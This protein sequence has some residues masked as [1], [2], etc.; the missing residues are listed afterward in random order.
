[1]ASTEPEKEAT[2]KIRAR[3]DRAAPFYDLMEG[4]IERLAF[5]KCRE[6]LFERVEGEEILEVGVGTGKNLPYYESGAEVI[7]IDFSPAM[8]SRAKSRAEIAEASVTLKEMDVQQLAFP[9]DHFDTSLSGFV[10]CSVPDPVKGM[11]EMKRVTKPEG[12]I[13][14]L[15]HMRPDNLILGAIFDLANPVV[16]RLLGPN[17]NRE[18]MKNIREAGL[19]VER[20]KSLTRF[21]IVRI[22]EAKP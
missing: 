19:E 2:N 5:R 7:A 13:L 21:G 10:F 12:K 4:S 18:T 15:E 22:I 6:R 8:L 16:V 17:I 3:Y 14:L 20:T 9:D 1:M 11:E